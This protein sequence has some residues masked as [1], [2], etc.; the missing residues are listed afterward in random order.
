MPYLRPTLHGK[1]RI[2]LRDKLPSI[3]TPVISA[4]PAG[5]C[6]V[7]SSSLEDSRV[8]RWPL[9]DKQ[10]WFSRGG[11][12]RLGAANFAAISPR[13]LQIKRPTVPNPD[14]FTPD[15]L[16]IPKHAHRDVQRPLRNASVDLC[17]LQGI[18]R[19]LILKE[20]DL[21]VTLTWPW[22]QAAPFLWL[23]CRPFDG[24]RAS[25]TLHP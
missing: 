17:R 25:Y 18:I 5:D 9:F 21:G 24:E 3:A 15:L 2:A 6:P 11:Y 14:G 10:L 23:P 1:H 16:P 19:M 20:C 12:V 8:C 4:I 7:V 22:G 13:Y